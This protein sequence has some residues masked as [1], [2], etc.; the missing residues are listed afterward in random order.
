MHFSRSALS[1]A[2]AAGLL[3]GCAGSSLGSSSSIPS[4]G[5]QSRYAAQRHGW[6]NLSVVPRSKLGRHTQRLAV[7]NVKPMVAVRGQFVSEYYGTQVFGYAKQNK[8]NN[9]PMC[10]LSGNTSAVNGI[11]SD[12]KGNVIVPGGDEGSNP[13]YVSIYSAGGSSG[14]AF[15]ASIP[16]TTGESAD[17]ASYNAATGNIAVAEIV[18]WTT[19]TGDVVMCSVAGGC[20]TPV[21]N[22]AITGYGGGVALAPNGD[23][24]LSAATSGT[25]GFNLIYWQ[26][27][28]GSGQ[29]A[30]GT[31][32][33]SYGGLFFDSAGNL[34][35]VDAFSNVLYVYSGCNPNCTL[36]GGPFALEG[37]SFYGNLNRAG[38]RLALGDWA[39]GQ[40]DVYNYSDTPSG[41]TLTYK[42]NF[43]NSLTQGDLVESGIFSPSNNV[44]SGGGG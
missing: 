9:P 38:N 6:G 28:T 18:N 2:V 33:S 3:A 19:G 43:N 39:N 42:Y 32:N 16:D 34:V 5:A 44:P 14:C 37:A 1:L 17:A 36:K 15:L 23:C 41:V 7:G 22:P 30:T 35:S 11:A 8:A 31:L 20:G 4:A 12:P 24:W 40:V 10:E 29:V 27:C 13:A 25:S 26:G 21:T